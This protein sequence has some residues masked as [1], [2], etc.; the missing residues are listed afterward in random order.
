[1]VGNINRNPRPRMASERINPLYGQIPMPI[2][3]LAHVYIP[4]IQSAAAEIN[5]TREW[6]RNW[7]RNK[8]V[9]K[10]KANARR[11]KKKRRRCKR[12]GE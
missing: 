10:I 5:E 6:L 2:M 1:M 12:K 7:S 9:Q 11:N 3:K 8:W 4:T